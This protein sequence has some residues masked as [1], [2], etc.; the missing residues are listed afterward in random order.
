MAIPVP[1]QESIYLLNAASYDKNKNVFM[2]MNKVFK[3]HVLSQKTS[4]LEKISLIPR[5][6]SCIIKDEEGI[7]IIGGYA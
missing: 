1:F 6:K 2:P 5:I 7:Y 3:I 4:V